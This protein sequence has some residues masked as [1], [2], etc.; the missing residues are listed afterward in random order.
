MAVMDFILVQNDDMKYFRVN[1][2][3]PVGAR[4]ERTEE[5]MKHL[6]AVA[7]QLPEK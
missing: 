1:V 5:I 6:E 7:L 3:L 4:L 2:E